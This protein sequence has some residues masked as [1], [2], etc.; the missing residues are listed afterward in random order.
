MRSEAAVVEGLEVIPVDSLAQAVAFFAG[1]IELSPAP[2]RTGTNCLND[3]VATTSTSV[4]SV[5]KN[6]P[7][8]R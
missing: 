5:A 6:R 7:S 4:T 1:E 3:S 2:S 8:V